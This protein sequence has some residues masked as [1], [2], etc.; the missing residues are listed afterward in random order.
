MKSLK[1]IQ[2]MLVRHKEDLK[3]RYGVREIGIF[4]SYVRGEAREGSDI[5]ILVDFESPLSLLRIVPLEN[6]LQDLLGMKVDLVSKRNV[7]RELEKEIFNEV[8]FL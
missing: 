5:D 7:R 3:A 8:V 2:T 4:G 1:E 6:E